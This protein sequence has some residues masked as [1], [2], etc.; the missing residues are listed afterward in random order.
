MGILNVCQRILAAASCCVTLACGDG[1]LTAFESQPSGLIDDFEDLNNH[2]NNGVGWWYT[3]NDGSG[4][5]SF[6]IVQP[7]DRPGNKGALH[8]YGS[9]FTGWGAE[10]GVSLSG[11]GVGGTFDASQFSGIEFDAEVAAGANTAMTVWIADSTHSFSFNV[12][13]TSVWAR[14]EVP[15]ASVVYSGDSALKLNSSELFGVQFSFVGSSA[16][17]LWLDNVTFVP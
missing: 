5:Q 7:L 6:E 8:T 16:F 12:P 14:Y 15:F 4:S 2:A 17:G 11:S 3:V 13:I 10:V 9:G 1:K